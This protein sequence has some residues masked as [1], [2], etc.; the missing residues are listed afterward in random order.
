MHENLTSFNS[1]HGAGF[2]GYLHENNR[3]EAQPGVN[4]TPYVNSC[5]NINPVRENVVTD[6]IE[7]KALHYGVCFTLH[8]WIARL[9]DS[10]SFKRLK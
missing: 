3:I 8:C 9:F 5:Q 2:L 10:V 6:R 7:M 1:V 4:S